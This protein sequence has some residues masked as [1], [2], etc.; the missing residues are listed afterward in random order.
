MGE[1]TRRTDAEKNQREREEKQSVCVPGTVRRRP[2]NLVKN[3]AV[4]LVFQARYQANWRR[5]HGIQG[6]EREE[7]LMTLFLLST[8]RRFPMPSSWR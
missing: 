6:R 5:E 4:G 3:F 7:T 8:I 1:S 2:S